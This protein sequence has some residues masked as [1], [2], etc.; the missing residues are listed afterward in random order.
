MKI[1]MIYQYKHTLW[2]NV[3]YIKT[4]HENERILVILINKLLKSQ[5]K[6]QITFFNMLKIMIDC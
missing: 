2:S 4:I 3:I 1:D 5:L 6:P